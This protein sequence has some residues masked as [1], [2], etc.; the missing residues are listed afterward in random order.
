ML[1]LNLQST[2]TLLRVPSPPFDEIKPFVDAGFVTPAAALAMTSGQVTAAI[3]PGDYVELIAG[4]Q[5]GCRAR[6]V[7]CGDDTASVEIE[8]LDLNLHPVNR[9]TYPIDVPLRC[10]RRLFR[11]GDSIRVREGAGEHSGCSG[12]I[13]DIFDDGQ[14]LIF[15]EDKTRNTVSPVVDITE[16]TLTNKRSRSS[17]DPW[18]H[19]SPITCMPTL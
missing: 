12:C 4:E 9:P 16:A 18:S 6:V 3:Q 10:L 1:I 19:I 14:R 2:C 17:P 5:S 7:I 11:V 15:V 13:V 8:P